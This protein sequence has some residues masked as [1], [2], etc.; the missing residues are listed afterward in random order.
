MSEKNLETIVLR[1]TDHLYTTDGSYREHVLEQIIN[2][3]RKDNY[4]YLEDFQWYIELLTKMTQL[5][6]MSKKNAELVSEQLMDV[7]IRVAEV[8]DFAVEQMVCN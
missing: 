7:A 1:L 2:V 6:T 8:R 5:S 3:C 4:K